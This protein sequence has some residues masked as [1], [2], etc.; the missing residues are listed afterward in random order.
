MAITARRNLERRI[1]A[2][3]WLIRVR[4]LLTLKLTLGAIYMLTLFDFNVFTFD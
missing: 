3:D 4:H 1:S 2:C